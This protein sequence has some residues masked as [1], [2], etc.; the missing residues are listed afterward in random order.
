QAEAALAQDVAA[1]ARELSSRPNRVRHLVAGSALAAVLLTATALMLRTRAEPAEPADAGIASD[2]KETGP[3]SPPI[4]AAAASPKPEASRL[5]PAKKSS[6]GSLADD[7]PKSISIKRNP[8][9]QAAEKDRMKSPSAALRPSTSDA[10][11]QAGATAPV[12]ASSP[13]DTS[14]R[15]TAPVAKAAATD[16]A[17]SP[18]K[19]EGANGTAGKYKGSL[20]VATEP[21][22]AQGCV[23]RPMVGG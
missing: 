14:R 7:S 19:P 16:V 3:D 10:K 1:V 18:S 17:G 15:K 23:D 13:P 6:A 9:D 21:A 12:A 22:G 8:R 11:L 4:A 5:N 20:Q 2:V